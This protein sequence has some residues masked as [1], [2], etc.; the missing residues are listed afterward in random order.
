MLENRL[1]FYSASFGWLNDFSMSVLF[2]V[3]RW[4]PQETR[5]AC[6]KRQA[7]LPSALNDRTEQSNFLAASQSKSSSAKDYELASS[8][9]LPSLVDSSLGTLLRYS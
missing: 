6:P 1:E 7:F 5:R 2:E 8:S 4:V 9:H 3:L